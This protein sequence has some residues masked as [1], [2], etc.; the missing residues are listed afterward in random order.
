MAGK[1]SIKNGNKKNNGRNNHG[2]HTNQNSYNNEEHISALI[3]IL[4]FL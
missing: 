4:V 2:Y 1:E 3:V